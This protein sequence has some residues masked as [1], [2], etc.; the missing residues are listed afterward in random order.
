MRSSFSGPTDLK[1]RTACHDGVLQQTR[2]VTFANT[3]A[4]CHGVPGPQD[5]RCSVYVYP[6]CDRPQTESAQTDTLVLVS[7]SRNQIQPGCHTSDK[8]PNGTIKSLEYSNSIRRSS[9]GRFCCC[10]LAMARM[11]SMGSVNQQDVNADGD[12]QNCQ[13]VD[14]VSNRA[15]S[16]TRTRNHAP[17]C[18]TELLQSHHGKMTTDFRTS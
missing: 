16:L 1:T 13:R 18:T 3:G 6:A 12:V 5:S 7:L 9:A 4:N 11:S 10:D 8:Q 2:F 14:N 15:W 17:V